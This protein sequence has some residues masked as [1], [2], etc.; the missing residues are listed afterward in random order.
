MR[1][2]VVPTIKAPFQESN[3]TDTTSVFGR[4]RAQLCMQ[5]GPFDRIYPG[6][7][8]IPQAKRF[9]SSG[10]M[11]SSENGDIQLNFLRRLMIG[12]IY[13]EVTNHLLF[14]PTPASSSN[15]IINPEYQLKELGEMIVSAAERALLTVDPKKRL[16]LEASLL[17]GITED[18]EG[19]EALSQEE[20]LVEVIE[21]VLEEEENKKNSQKTYKKKASSTKKEEENIPLRSKEYENIEKIVEDYDLRGKSAD[22]RQDVRY[23]IAIHLY[24]NSLLAKNERK[25]QEEIAELFHVSEKTVNRVSMLIK[26]LTEITPENFGEKK[27]GRKNV[28]QLTREQMDEFKE[29]LKHTTDTYG[30]SYSTWSGKCIKQY[31]EKTFNLNWSLKKVFKFLRK[32]GFVS[33][34]AK[35]INLKRD[36][37]K[38]QQ[39]KEKL[40]SIIKSYLQEGYSPIW[41]DETGVRQGANI[42]GYAE[43]ANKA[44][45]TNSTETLH[46]GHS[47]LTF[48]GFNTFYS[49]IYEGSYNFEKFI[50]VLKNFLK[51]N[52]N[53][54]FVLFGDNYSVHKKVDSLL[55]EKKYIGLKR[56]IRFEYIPEYC[57]ELNP[58][59]FFNCDFKNELKRKICYSALDVLTEA[60]HYL[61]KFMT[62]DG[63]V[64][65]SAIRDIRNFFK[66]KDCKFTYEAYNNALS[67]FRKEKH[68]FE[69][70]HDD[71]INNLSCNTTKLV[72]KYNNT[73]PADIGNEFLRLNK[74]PGQYSKF[75]N[76]YKML[77]ARS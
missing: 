71:L 19:N 76:N 38:I 65:K 44:V 49:E 27:R 10:G 45:M 54:K 29:A 57:P 11:A 15:I 61:K 26:N 37:A 56:R 4:F 70:L 39:Y 5:F 33:K 46:T 58:V 63:K 51:K 32:N 62:D 73:I 18:E 43:S 55:S 1:L 24:K 48:L 25:T 2:P 28:E 77:T 59:E 68:I 75:I 60:S 14:Y 22:I 17:G 12:F 35:K 52:P 36:I 50:L 21:E 42:R 9:W 53:K 8:A 72:E 74:T 7:L 30:L 31:F 23:K 67:E 34:V 13:E 41:Y 69:K 66:A 47:L 6:G 40:S 16:S 64:Q 3:I 20:L